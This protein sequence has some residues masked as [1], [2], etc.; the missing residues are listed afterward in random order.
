MGIRINR[1]GVLGLVRDVSFGW[2]AVSSVSLL[3]PAEVVTI[4]AQRGARRDIF[5][6]GWLR[7][8]APVRLAPIP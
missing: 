6:E 5:P 2:S 7:I 1:L 4:G 8:A 3:S